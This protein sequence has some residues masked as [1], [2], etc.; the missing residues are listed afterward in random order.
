MKQTKQ[1]DSHY[2]S[3]ESP[4]F[5]PTVVDTQHA[6]IEEG[7]PDPLVETQDG[8]GV[9]TGHSQQSDAAPEE[10]G[11]QAERDVKTSKATLGRHVTSAAGS[12][13]S[14]KRHNH[15]RQAKKEGEKV[16][17]KKK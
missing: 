9:L 12:E 2:V 4:Q 5:E 7:H 13:V 6:S 10:I 14:A 11:G 15:V 17:S 16:F 8:L 1:H 3:H